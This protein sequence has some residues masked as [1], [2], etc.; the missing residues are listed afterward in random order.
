MNQK[1]KQKNAG[2]DIF[3]KV[4]IILASFFHLNYKECITVHWLRVDQFKSITCS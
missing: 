3:S 1:Y 4:N 2:S